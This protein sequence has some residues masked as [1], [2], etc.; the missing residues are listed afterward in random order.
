M[1][2]FA[3]QREQMVVEQI[4]ARGV[5]D[6]KVLDAMGKVRREAFLPKNLHEQAYDDTPLSIAVGQTISQPYIVAS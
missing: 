2:D 1:T 5:R 3:K 4:S 6:K